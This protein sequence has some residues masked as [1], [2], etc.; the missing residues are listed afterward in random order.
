MEEKSF[1]TRRQEALEALGGG[2]AH[3]AFNLFR[4]T[5][6]YPGVPELK[7]PG[8]WRQALETFASISDA[9]AGKE[10]ADGVRGALEESPQALYELGYQLV[11]QGLHGI[12]ATVLLR[13][14]RLA[15]GE[16]PL[17]TEL[18]VALESQGLNAEAT[19]FL[20]EVPERLEHSF[21]CRY[22]LAFNVLM[23]GDLD[24]PRRLLPGL[25]RLRAQAEGEREA[26][27]Y[28][29]MEDRLEQ[30][31]ARADAVRNVT[32]LDT[33][34]LR[35]WHF[36]V[37]GGVLLHVSPFGFDEGM[38]GRYAFTQDSEERCLEG[39]Q[40]VAEVLR[41]T[42]LKPPRV[43]VLPE[44]SSAILAHAAAQVLGVPAEP[45]PSE[46]SEEP[47]LIVAYALSGLDEPVLETLST[48]HAGQ[49]L[50][51][52]AVCWTQPPPC[53]P[54]LA[55]YLYQTNMSP[56]GKRFRVDAETRKME[57]VPPLTGAVEEL[58]RTVVSAKSEEEPL[59][60]LP[61]LSALV[62]ATKQARGS[63]VGGLFRREGPRR[64][65]FTDSPVKS[66]RFL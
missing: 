64:R 26:P 58:A 13:A 43:F 30:M 11:E 33:Q 38:R 8:R 66:N 14:L 39:I 54:D 44:R 59:A 20:R 23:T 4:W 37:T 42:G 62:K 47:G 25:A 41:A 22:L 51:C 36:V 53:A 12:A 24:E 6:E 19:R 65:M 35:G 16:E 18:C 15:P 55:T 32:P 10:F 28:A 1:E 2:E 57:T 49:I 63:A 21:L 3:E 50:W 40:R 31:L 9:I 34:D 60:D 27:A 56:W 52:H 29:H 17:L 7:E 61:T 46:G 45:W 5:L 48:H